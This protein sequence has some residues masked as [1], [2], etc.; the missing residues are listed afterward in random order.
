[1][2][3]L[4]TS[5]GLLDGLFSYLFRYGGSGEEIEGRRGKSHNLWFLTKA[6]YLDWNTAMCRLKALFVA[7]VD[8]AD[9]ARVDRDDLISDLAN[10]GEAILEDQLEAQK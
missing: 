8:L 7:I 10:L 5:F 4:L 6:L 9:S 3:D 1:M 2:G